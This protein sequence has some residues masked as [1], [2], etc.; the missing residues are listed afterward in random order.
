M[1]Q[2]NQY[3]LNL[4]ETSDT[5]SPAPLNENAQKL[6]AALQGG[7]AAATAHADAG[8]AAEAAARAADVAALDQRLQVFEAHKLVIGSAKAGEKVY[9]DFTPK[10]L[11]AKGT[12]TTATSSTHGTF[13]D[14]KVSGGLSFQ[15]GE[16]KHD[17]SFAN[18]S[19][20]AF[21]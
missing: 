14:G 13:F 2:T 8:D 7:L 1:Q 21:L 4:I 11:Y 15:D 3:Q 10:V 9:L 18:V 20:I 19:Y 12:S 5:F 6:E 17:G 16:L